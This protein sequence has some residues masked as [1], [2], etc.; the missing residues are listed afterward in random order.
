MTRAAVNAAAT[1]DAL[2]AWL[3]TQ[4]ARG[5]ATAA[6]A[7]SKGCPEEGASAEDLDGGPG[8]PD[9]HTLDVP[10]TSPAAG[11]NAGVTQPAERGDAARRTAPMRLAHTDWLHHRLA[12]IGA[13][14]Q[15]AAF[16]RAAAGAGIT[17]WQIDLNRL[18]E[19]VFHLLVAPPSLQPRTLSVAG[20]R[21]L[22]GQLREA[23]GRRHERAVAHVGVSQACPFDLHTL[24]PVPDHVLRLGPDDPVA[25]AWLWEHW[26]TTQ[27]LRH[28]AE[29]VAAGQDARCGPGLAAGHNAIHVT[30]WSADWTPWRA[31][32][33]LEK[34]WPRLRFDV[35][36]TYGAS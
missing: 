10:A 22:A 13:A 5:G 35:C 23:V 17:P 27:P 6:P 2:L 7:K 34:R 29:D 1:A 31:L 18:E 26:G 28:V 8:V 19:D 25:L 20:A 15:L 12:I 3:A 9:A 14:D 33:A 21:V 30:F 36:P 4:Q 16:R 24:V 11:Q 32:A